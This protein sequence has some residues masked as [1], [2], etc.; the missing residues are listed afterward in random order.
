VEKAR[1]GLI[2]R[3]FANVD[4]VDNVDVVIVDL[5]RDKTQRPTNL[6]LK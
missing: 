5:P 2:G 1:S 6:H 3:T 4:I